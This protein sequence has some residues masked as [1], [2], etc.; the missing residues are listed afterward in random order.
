M[1]ED[2][3]NYLSRPSILSKYK[4][5]RLIVV[6]GKGGVGKTS[7][8]MAMTKVI[9]D[10]GSKVLYNSFDQP[11]NEKLAASQNIPVLKLD[12]ESSAKRYI[13]KKLG[14]ETLASWILKTPFF[15][16][17]FNMLPGLGHMILL[18]HLINLLEEDPDLR[19]VVDSPSSGHAL[20]MFESPQ[21]FKKIFRAGLIVDDIKRMEDFLFNN[22]LM[23]VFIVSLPTKMSVQ[24]AKD[25]R[26]ELSARNINQVS[27]L[28]NNLI[29]LNPLL[30]QTKPE[31]IP[32]FLEQ[33][34]SIEKEVL[35]ETVVSQNEEWNSIPHYF[36]DSA[37]DTLSELISHI[38]EREEQ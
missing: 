24:E 9:A 32:S 31:D 23:R 26:E 20:T 5:S 4:N 7:I 10:S 25:L 29:S 6:T 18:G 2:T 30:I 12:L 15:K 36:T 33:K 8:A 27:M 1:K 17:L 28:A 35:S 34:I 37:E 3:T 22:E 19:I 21:N 14:S 11:Y 13:S 38:K 16:S